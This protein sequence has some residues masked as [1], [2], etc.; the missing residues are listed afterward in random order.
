MMHNLFAIILAMKIIKK[1]VNLALV[2]SAFFL[3]PF[4][5]FDTKNQKVLLIVVSITL[6]HFNIKQWWKP[7][8]NELQTKI[9]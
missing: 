6:K 5:A 2:C 9:N 3:F 4:S 7:F 1:K 8:F